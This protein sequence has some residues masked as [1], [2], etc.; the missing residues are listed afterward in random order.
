MKQDQQKQ[1]EK[2]YVVI[3]GASL[4]RQKKVKFEQHKSESSSSSE[5]SKQSDISNKEE[6]KVTNEKSKLDKS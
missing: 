5:E 2:I 1:V 6:V 4:R 3:P